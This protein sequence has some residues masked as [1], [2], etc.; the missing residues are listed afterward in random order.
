M[1]QHE[2]KQG[3]YVIEPIAYEDNYTINAVELNGTRYNKFKE[4]FRNSEDGRLYEM[5]LPM[6]DTF[7]PITLETFR[8]WRDDFEYVLLELTPDDLDS[9][10]TSG[11]LEY[12]GTKR[13][14]TQ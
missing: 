13:E 5:E 11:Q 9:K 2:Q 1:R 10:L 8:H 4:V 3:H 14:F 12:A 6:G 7:E